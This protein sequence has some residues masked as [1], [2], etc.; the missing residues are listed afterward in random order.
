MVCFIRWAST[1]FSPDG[2]S[3]STILDRVVCW[4]CVKACLVSNKTGVAFIN[5][6]NGWDLAR[7]WWLDIKNNMSNTFQI[8]IPSINCWLG[9]INVVIV[10]NRWSYKNGALTKP[11]MECLVPSAVIMLSFFQK[12]LILVVLRV[13]RILCLTQCNLHHYLTN[14]KYLFR[15]DRMLQRSQ[16]NHNRLM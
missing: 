6:I 1:I 16:N 12:Y 15:A 10:F 11:F 2:F 3:D 9:P 5:F 8:S 7:F 13:P 14:Q 4:F